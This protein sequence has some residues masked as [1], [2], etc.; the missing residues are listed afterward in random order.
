MMASSL[1]RQPHNFKYHR[2]EKNHHLYKIRLIELLYTTEQ[3]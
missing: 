2:H 1:S 3:T